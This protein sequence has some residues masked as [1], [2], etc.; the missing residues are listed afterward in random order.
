MFV[1]RKI[2]KYGDSF[3]ISLPRKVLQIAD[4]KLNDSVSITPFKNKIIIEKLE[5]GIENGKSSA[6]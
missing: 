6:N 2:K 4:M 1:K 5:E 3:V